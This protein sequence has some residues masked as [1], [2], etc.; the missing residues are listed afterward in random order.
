MWTTIGKNIANSIKKQASAHSAFAKSG[1]VATDDTTA[2]ELVKRLA[3]EQTRY[4]K[5]FLLMAKHPSVTLVPTRGI[6]LFWHERTLILRSAS[7]CV[8][9]STPR[10]ARSRRVS[11]GVRSPPGRQANQSQC[12]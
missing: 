8:L 10:H 2:E 9:I 7:V 3:W 6:D 12:A 5:F 11:G 4:E 1:L